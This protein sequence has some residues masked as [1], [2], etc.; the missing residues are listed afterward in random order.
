MRNEYSANRQLSTSKANTLTSRGAWHDSA[1][2][3]R[4]Q[5]VARQWRIVAAVVVALLAT[6]VAYSL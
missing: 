4:Q 3:I 5:R 2:R 1:K 6:S